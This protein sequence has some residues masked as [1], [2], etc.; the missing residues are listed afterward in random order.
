M[1]DREVLEETPKQMQAK[2]AG[3]MFR[4]FFSFFDRIE[5]TCIIPRKRIV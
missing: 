2:Q 4:R 1:Q 5:K 3:Q